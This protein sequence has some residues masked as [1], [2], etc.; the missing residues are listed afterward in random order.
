[1]GY[2]LGGGRGGVYEGSWDPG[3]EEGAVFLEG[4]LGEGGGIE[5]GDGGEGEEAGHGE[6]GR[7][8]SS[9]RWF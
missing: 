3:A 5:E 1:M 4:A 9:V 6:R 2:G 8:G 7:I